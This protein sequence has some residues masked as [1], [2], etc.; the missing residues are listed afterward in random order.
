MGLY[1]SLRELGGAW[2]DAKLRHLQ[3]RPQTKVD[4][5]GSTDSH[6]FD[7]QE[8]S[9][10]DLED[11]KE[12]RESG[13]V[14]S[15]LVHAKA[16]MQFGTGAEWQTDTE[17]LVDWLDE[18]FPH[19][20][21]L[22]I[23]L[24]E[25]AIWF[26]YAVAET[27]E[28]QGGG[29]S[30]VEPVEPWTMQPIE[31]EYGEVIAWEQEIG[32]EVTTF[33][34]EELATIILNK[35]CGRDNTGISE[36]LRAEAEIQGFREN[37]QTVNK[38]LEFLVPHNHWIV[39][40]ES[41]QVIDD[42]ELR[43][44]RN[45]VD[46]MEGDTQFITGPDVDHN[47][48]SLQE[49]DYSGIQER[50]LREVALALGLPLELANIGSDGLGSG[51]PADLRLTLFERQARAAQRNLTAQVD[52]GII[53]PVIEQYSPFSVDEY[54]GL[55][56]SDPIAER[57][58]S[59]LGDIAPYMKLNEIRE[60]L[61]KPPEEDDE[62]GDSYRKPAN[63]EAPEEEEPEDD[64]GIG[65]F[66]SDRSLGDGTPEWD[67]HFLDLHHRIWNADADKQLVQF[68]N[69]ETPEFVKNRLRDAIWSGSVF[70]D[71]ENVPS[72]ELT[73]LREFLTEQLESENWSIDGIADQ[74]QDLEGATLSADEAETIA[75]TETA[76]TVN[77]ARSIGYEE[78]GEGDDR[79]YWVG[80]IDDRTT[81]ACTWLLEQTNPSHGGDP[82]ALEKLQELIEEAPTHDPDMDDNLARPENFIVHPNERKTFVRHVE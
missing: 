18:Q 19:I 6:L 4:S 42:N 62:L 79:F 26:P 5:G 57:E 61:D 41:G 80:N 70:S 69:S 81:E 38:A 60:E 2:K 39:G 47:E 17:D 66:F 23:E 73:S 78:R 28:T 59:T 64:G 7:A 44:V 3:G 40:K 30:H 77:T 63:I 31:N 65:G 15:Y 14:I 82:V 37:R 49:F 71:F 12:I 53:E 75:R 8:T 43:R 48:I 67:Q 9:R 34:P 13:G 10:G 76:S 36:V 46:N 20:D 11:V 16:L 74:L 21:N 25:D 24:G 27:V 45:L 35:S 29:F 33:D 50:D 58:E 22:L 56:L 52:K 54:D 72:S 55:R 32:R 68:N 1:S 51:M